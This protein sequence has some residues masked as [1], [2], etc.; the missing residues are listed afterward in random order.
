MRG[1]AGA[2]M[3]NSTTGYP[4]ARRFRSRGVRYLGVGIPAVES[5]R[6]PKGPEISGRR[7]GPGQP[8]QSSLMFANQLFAYATSRA[9][10]SGLL[11]LG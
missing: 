4:I 11:S 3:R 2:V 10:I 1:M 5:K 8:Q 7:E 9:R 6:A